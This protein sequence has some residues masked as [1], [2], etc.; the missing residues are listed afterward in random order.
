MAMTILIYCWLQFDAFSAQFLSAT[1]MRIVP[2]TTAP[3]AS[4]ANIPARTV[5]TQQSIPTFITSTSPRATLPST[6]KLNVD[7]RSV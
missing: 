5:I 1:Q 4:Q 2:S 7:D 3:V 6:C